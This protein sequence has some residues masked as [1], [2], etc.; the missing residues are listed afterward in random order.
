MGGAVDEFGI[1]MEEAKKKKKA[2]S[3]A[4][5]LGTELDLFL[6]PEDGKLQYKSIQV[7]KVEAKHGIY[8]GNGEATRVSRNER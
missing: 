2:C 5:L 8:N 7:E 1:Q 4:K 3:S 6:A